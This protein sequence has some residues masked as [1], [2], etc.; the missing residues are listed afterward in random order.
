MVFGKSKGQ[1]YVYA[2]PIVLVLLVL[3]ISIPVFP[4]QQI[5]ISIENKHIEDT[6][7]IEGT[8]SIFSI[9]ASSIS[10]KTVS[11]RKLEIKIYNRTGA[12]CLE[13]FN[14]NDEE[15]APV[16]N[17]TEWTKP[18]SDVNSSISLSKGEYISVIELY[19]Y[20]SSENAMMLQ[21][22]SE[23]SFAVGE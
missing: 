15:C 2:A 8:T 1:A 18:G 4:T 10:E 7:Y 23:F 21:E 5:S 19:V 12:D 20:S 22:E 3:F 14:R 16:L 9:L 17:K 11:D 13:D 6:S